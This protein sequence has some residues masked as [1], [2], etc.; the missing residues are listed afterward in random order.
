MFCNG[1]DLT[2]EQV[3][4]NNFDILYLKALTIL[5]DGAKAK[6]TVQEL[7]VH[8]WEKKDLIKIKSSIEAYLLISIHNNC[9][10]ALTK[11]QK[12]KKRLEGYIFNLI[13]EE[14]VNYIINTEEYSAENNWI[15]ALKGARNSLSYNQQ[16]V[17][18]KC[19]DEGKTYEQT[20]K[21]MNIKRNT[22]HSHIERSFSKF[23]KIFSEKC[24]PLL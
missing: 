12:E 13:Q 3:Y 18:I 24:G 6:D 16:Q 17:I 23:R 7:F 4:K 5:D 20:A 19:F 9:I 22:V 14:A 10:K 11:D 21:E 8:L 1:V 15:F 2:F